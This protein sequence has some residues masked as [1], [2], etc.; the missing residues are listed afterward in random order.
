MPPFFSYNYI[1]II[2]MPLFY[3][4]QFFLRKAEQLLF[5]NYHFNTTV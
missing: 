2:L 4:E 1:F 3:I 5:P